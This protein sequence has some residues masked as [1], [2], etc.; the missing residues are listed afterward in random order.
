MRK[1]FLIVLAAAALL[2]AMSCKSTPP[3]EPVPLPETELAKAKE[4]KAKVDLYKLG[5]LAQAEYTVAENDMKAGEDAYGKDNAAS[6]AS[7]DKAITG[8]QAVIAKAGPL[9]L[10]TISD[11]TAA[12]KKAADDLKASVAVKDDYAKAQAVYDRA[13]AAKTAGDLEAATKDFEEARKLFDAVAKV[14]QEKRD[15]ALAAGKDAAKAGE[16]SAA[17]AAEAQA[18]LE[19]ESFGK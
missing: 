9:Y 4:L 1:A 19:A 2:M 17:K 14:A 6:K 10:G 7:L 16:D 8:Y 18:A 11:R 12:A 13:L 3:V 15:K 5:P